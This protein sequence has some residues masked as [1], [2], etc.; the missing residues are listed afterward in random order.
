ML[1]RGVSLVLGAVLA[2]HA[3]P[4][5]AQKSPWTEGV[6]EENKTKAKALLD[7]GNTLLLDKK[8][9]EALDVYKQAITF[10]DHPAIRFNMV[11]CLIQLGKNL[12]A[13][14]SL[15]KALQY[16][17][18]P[19]EDTVYN[20]AL[21]Y[22]KLL[23]TQIGDLTVTCEQAD[24]ALTLDGQPLMKCPGKQ[25]KRVLS[26]QHQVVGTK[27]GLLTKTVEVVVAGG[28]PRTIEVKLDTLE[29]AARIEHRWPQWVP[30]SVFGGGLVVGGVGILFQVLGASQMDDYDRWVDERCTGN[31]QPDE[32]A[33][34]ADLKSGAELKSTVGVSL[35]ITGGAAV[36]TGAVM[37]FLNR[38]RT[39]YP[40]AVEVAPNTSGGATVSWR[41]NF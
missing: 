20:E 18:A 31:C 25:T 38:G 28:T 33:D 14:E 5:Y 30:W 34:V 11:R 6:S 29:K 26:G 4:S 10:W 22:Q 36:A 24:V 23:S 41:G 19:H 2:M 40:P 35:M 39:V 13:H 9:V 27:E 37:L 32:L 12:E 16:G 21:A 7:Q 15:E 8:Y 1:A 17:A 3:A